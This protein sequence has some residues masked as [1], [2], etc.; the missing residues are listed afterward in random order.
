M[1]PGTNNVL[2][3]SKSQREKLQHQPVKVGQVLGLLN[4]DDQSSMKEWKTGVIKTG[5][6]RSIIVVRMV[7]IF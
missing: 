1:P 5:H 3:K 2:N 7:S 6:T 4:T